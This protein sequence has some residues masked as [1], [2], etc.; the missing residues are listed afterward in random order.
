MQT[1]QTIKYL[2]VKDIKPM[3]TQ[4]KQQI[5]D[6]MVSNFINNFYETF[7]VKPKVKYK[8]DCN[9]PTLNEIFDAVQYEFNLVLPGRSL[10]QKTNDAIFVKYR[11]IYYRVA[12]EFKYSFHS[13]CLLT[14]QNHATVIHN[15]KNLS[16]NSPLTQKIIQKFKPQ[17]PCN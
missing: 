16:N 10:E 4:Q 13:M 15:L 6:K 5:A 1:T 17:T 7:G 3:E 9:I 2:N 8:V 11:A 14:G 12:R